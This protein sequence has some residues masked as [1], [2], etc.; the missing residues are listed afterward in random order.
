MERIVEA[1]ESCR[2][3]L[4]KLKV[5]IVDMP[6]EPTK[7]QYIEWAGNHLRSQRTVLSQ[8]LHENTQLRIEIEKLKSQIKYMESR[9]DNY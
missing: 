1:Y 8:E 9:N 6:E 5:A 7:D 3:S 4:L 2:A